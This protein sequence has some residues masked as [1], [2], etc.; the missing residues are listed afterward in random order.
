[1]SRTCPAMQEKK[2]NYRDGDRESNIRMV[3]GTIKADSFLH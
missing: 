1:M 3:T 2:S